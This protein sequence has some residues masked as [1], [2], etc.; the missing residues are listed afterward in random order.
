MIVVSESPAGQL[1]DLIEQVKS[2]DEVFFTDHAR[3]V[4][5]LVPVASGEELAP[6]QAAQLLGVYPE[7]LEELIR[8]GELSEHQSGGG[9]RL[10][11]ADVLEYRR[12]RSIRR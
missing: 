3:A 4:A 7:F 11:L 6:Q 10:Y 12:L 2:G 8:N 5:K 1:A 9:R